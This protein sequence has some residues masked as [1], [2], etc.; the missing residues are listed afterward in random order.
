MT[1]LSQKTTIGVFWNLLQQFASR[2]I[3]VLVTLIL[4]YFLSPNDFGLVAMIAVFVSIATSLMESGFK[5]ALIRLPDASQE[6]FNTAFYANISIGILSYFL[7]FMA[8]PLIANFYEEE[9]LI[10]L[11]RVAGVVVIIN[12]FQV[13]Q[14][15][16]LSRNMNFKA[17]FRAALP[18]SMLSAA[19]AI[20]IAYMGFGVWALIAQMI[21]YAL[22]VAIFL[23]WQNLWR[24]TRICSAD[25]LSAMYRFGY[26]LFV[27]ALIDT[28]FKNLYVI[29]IA[30]LFT[31]SI[32]GLYYF[33]DRIREIVVFQLVNSI[34]NVTYP[35]LSTMQDDDVRLKAGFRNVI[36]VTTF[37]LFPMIIFLA[38]LAEPLFR[39]LLA[40]KW[41]PAATYLQLMCLAGL[42]IP[43]NAINL[44]IL[45]V[46]GR[47]DLFLL[48]EVIKKI[49]LMLVLLVSFRFGVIGILIGQIVNSILAFIPNS[50]FSK[51]LIDYSVR[52]Q[53]TDILPG[54]LLTGT[55]G[56]IMF[57]WV[58]VVVW[59][60][61]K[62]LI[63]IGGAGLLAYI[64]VAYILN[65][66][67]L[68]LVKQLFLKLY[69]SNQA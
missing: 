24:P 66:H 36:S 63:V 33:A 48:L 29:V 55:I 69:E 10:V 49:M 58:N 13:V 39:L 26:K 34:Q 50:Y 42:I 7:L 57:F 47:S 23:W 8:A 21:G 65:M 22:S 28:V 15:A 18:A 5:Q 30:K 43:M 25:S 9:Q 67:S 31:A 61:F 52:E 46:K 27:S 17:Q 16:C 1:S 53:I 14:Y 3:T 4:A 59:H 40:E 41:W 64:L 45:Q 20:M 54:L 2:G 44:N 60:E 19:V 6:D 37:I 51:K 62:M 35:A 38:V 32:A 12:A 68:N 11:V 56:A